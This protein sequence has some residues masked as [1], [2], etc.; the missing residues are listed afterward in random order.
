[1]N[2]PTWRPIAL[3]LLLALGLGGR[4]GAVAG[5][6]RQTIVGTITDEMCANANHSAM[7][8]GDTDG[9][10]AKACVTYHSAVYVLYD[11]TTTYQIS[12]QKTA[13]ALA[14]KKVRV[15]GAVD[16][17]TRKITVDSMRAE[18]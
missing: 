4:P 6:E 7:K 3:L 10:C 5:Q 17:K 18:P 16:P 11:G 2:T 8:M 13:D 1:M 9:D 12:D 15:V 14:G